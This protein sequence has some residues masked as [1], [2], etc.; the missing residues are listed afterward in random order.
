MNRSTTMS[1]VKRMTTPSMMMI[2]IATAITTAI[3]AAT[4][5]AIRKLQFKPPWQQRR[6]LTRA[7]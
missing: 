2:M 1:S 6:N 7:S 5:N 3:N 4:T